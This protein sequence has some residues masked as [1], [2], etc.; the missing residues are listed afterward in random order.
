MKKFAC[1]F[2]F[3]GMFAMVSAEELSGQEADE[4]GVHPYK[5][6]DTIAEK[7]VHWSLYFP[8]GATIADMDESMGAKLNNG[9][10]N[11]ASV[12]GGFGIQYDFTPTWGLAGEFVVTNY[13]KASF[14]GRKGDDGLRVDKDGNPASLGMAYNMSINLLYDFADA[15]FPRRQSTLFSCYGMLGA[16]IGCY[17]YQSEFDKTWSSATASTKNLDWMKYDRAAFLNFGLDLDFNVTR[18]FGLGARVMYTYYLSDNL[19]WSQ[20]KADATG[21]GSAGVVN[22]ANQF[23]DGLF[24]TD[25][26]LRYKI[27]ADPSSHMRNMARG[28]YDRLHERELAEREAKRLLDKMPR[29]NDTI[30]IHSGDTVFVFTKE[31][32]RCQHV[33]FDN[34][35]YTIKN[36]GLVTIQQAA[37]IY[38][39]EQD[40]YIVI[41][42]YC[43]NT[44]G[45]EYNLQLGQ[46]RAYEVG[47]EFE[48]EYGI[49]PEHI[50]RLGKG[51]IFSKRR[52][53]SFAPN[54][55]AEIHIVDRATFEGLKE[56]YAE[57]IKLQ[58]EYESG[59]RKKPTVKTAAEDP[60]TPE[61]VEELRPL[62]GAGSQLVVEDNMTLTSIANQIYGNVYCWVYIYQANKHML[63][64]PH[65]L[66]SGMILRIPELTED[67]LKTTKHQSFELLNRIEE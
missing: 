37:N 35:D 2:A 18:Q 25:I 43:D 31:K 8:V 54:R 64:S 34:D 55:R 65:N 15:L 7:M 29:K 36:E 40:A 13:G 26:I 16:G 30:L 14:T 42:G 44:G 9:G 58:K 48:M 27:D 32:E 20:A 41:I 19:D 63:H 46:Q 22:A 52:A 33:Y 45:K 1:L 28:L 10:L 39:H 56:I 60:V 21:N 62:S 49:D 5:S 38:S 12:N 17:Q 4:V 11:N 3:L 53:G 67:Q 6:Q 23:G 61:S 51:I 66:Q 47:T 59:N 24:Q 50:A 57:D